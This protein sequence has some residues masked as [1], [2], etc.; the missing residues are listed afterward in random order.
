[1]TASVNTGRFIFLTI[2]QLNLD[3]PT[4]AMGPQGGIPYNRERIS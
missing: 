3:Q 2:E 4:S 1:M